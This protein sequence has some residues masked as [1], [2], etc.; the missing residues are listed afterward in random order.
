MN[1]AL[2]LPADVADKWEK[3]L[4]QRQ[5]T[6]TNRPRSLK[7]KGVKFTDKLREC[8]IGESQAYTLYRSNERAKAHGEVFTPSWLVLDMLNDLP[9]SV[10]EEGETFC[11]PSC[12][13][14][15]FLAAVVLVKYWAGHKRPLES[16]FG[17]DIL[18][19]NVVE[20]KQRLRR[21]A[22]FNYPDMNEVDD[23]LNRNIVC[24]DA[25]KYHYRFDGT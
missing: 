13:N 5:N 15:Q 17:V 23:I 22:F 2:N 16:T 9:D 6:L 25:L 7:T 10:W 11:D 4:K 24:A 20:C 21:L 14:G 3:L 12:G 19:D 18:E 8:V 1:T